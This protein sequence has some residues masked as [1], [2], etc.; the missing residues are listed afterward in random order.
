MNMTGNEAGCG[1]HRSPLFRTS[2]QLTAAS[3]RER[4]TIQTWRGTLLA[5]VFGDT[6]PAKPNQS[7]STSHEDLPASLST[8]LCG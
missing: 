6:L 5:A 1:K 3:S 8:A 7:Q 2:V 4:C